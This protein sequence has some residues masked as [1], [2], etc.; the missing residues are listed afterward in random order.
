MAELLESGPGCE[1]GGI[2]EA[3][4]IHTRKIFDSCRDKDCV[5][6]LR[7]YPAAGC[8]AI[9]DRAISLKAGKAELL[10][11]YIDVE[12]VSFN[13]GFYTVDVRYFYKVS[14]DAFI[15][16]SRP[17]AICGL[18]VYDKRAILF[19][20]EGSAKVFSSNMAAYD[21]DQQSLPG[22]NLPIAVVEAVD[23]LILG[24]KLVDPGDKCPCCC[25]GCEP[26]DVPAGIAACFPEG[27]EQGGEGRRVYVTLGQFSIIRLERDSQLLIPAYDYCVPQK[28]CPGSCEEDPCSVFR[29][30]Q[31]PMEE[32]FPPNT[33][34][35]PERYQEAKSCCES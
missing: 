21:L 29:R 32:F 12:P 23:P 16:A 5:E 13:R 15:G 24:I 9:I 22:A 7:F 2:R 26:S 19:G 31:F 11:V 10:Y 25:C 4:C 27:L 8:Q 6:N 33:T 28:E 34:K 35:P 14:A 17:M 30:V 3:V 20:S 18:T 1:A